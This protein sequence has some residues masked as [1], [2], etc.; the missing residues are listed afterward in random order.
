MQSFREDVVGWSTLFSPAL[1]SPSPSSSPSAKDFL[2]RSPVMDGEQGSFLQMSLVHQD[3]SSQP[4]SLGHTT[5]RDILG[6]D[7]D[8][9]LV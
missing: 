6:W 7:K 2:I 8:K 5:V 3:S 4:L 9:D 1:F